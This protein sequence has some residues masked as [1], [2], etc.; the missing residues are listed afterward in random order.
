MEKTSILKNVPL[1]SGATLGGR[2]DI[3]DHT[4]IQPLYIPRYEQIVVTLMQDRSTLDNDI[5]VY[6]KQNWVVK[7]VAAGSQGLITFVLERY[8]D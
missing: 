4:P 3:V 6:L 8:N 7:H 2:L 5:S 1:E